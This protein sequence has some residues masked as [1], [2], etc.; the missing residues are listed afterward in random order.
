M[1]LWLAA[2]AQAAAAL[3]PLQSLRYAADISTNLG[4]LAV[5]AGRVVADETSGDVT[6]VPLSGLAD[7]AHV[8]AYALLDNGDQLLSFDI[9][10]A[11]P[12]DVAALP[13][14]LVRFDGATYSLV[15]S[16]AAF[17]IA[18]GANLDAVAVDGGQLLLSFDGT[19]SAGGVIAAKGD[20]LALDEGTFSLRFDASSVGLGAGLDLDAA[21]VVGGHLFLSFDGSGSIGGLLFDDDD[22][23]EY[24]PV[25]NTWELAF[26]ASARFGDF[27][28]ANLTA[29]A[30]QPAPPTPTPTSE[31]T[32]TPEPTDTPLPTSTVPPLATATSQPTDTP[33]PTHT[34]AP[35]HTAVP[36][37]TAVPT[38]TSTPPPTHTAEPSLTATAVASATATFSPTSSPSPTSTL[39]STA[40][41]TATRSATATSTPTVPVPTATASATV[42]ATLPEPT[43]TGGPEP[44][45]GD[46]SADG[47][48]TVDELL[49]MVNIALG[50][51]DPSACPPG[52]PSGDGEVTIDEILT[53]TNA[54][55]NGC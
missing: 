17:G 6:A 52:D 18:A 42:T 19:V 15:F 53:A 1:T 50:S 29:L 31:F 47:E 16:A 33:V 36:T 26:D 51:A 39:P 2:L 12:G 46:C 23:L 8:D 35:T 54:A 40:T 21:D 37:D 27:G 32:I 38:H 24:D 4:G 25:A 30:V 22:V 55:L 20:L 9:S 45:T 10:V 28:S 41:S 11:L 13:A 43:A 48:V 3:T 5:P 14:D 44:C 49:L 7:G 34:P